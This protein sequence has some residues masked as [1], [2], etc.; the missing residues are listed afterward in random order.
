MDVIK[1]EFQGVTA[2]SMLEFLKVDDTLV[3]E[4]KLMNKIQ[5]MGVS[6]VDIE[7]F[8]SS[9]NEVNMLNL[10]DSLSRVEAK[11]QKVLQDHGQISYEVMNVVALAHQ[12]LKDVLAMHGNWGK[13]QLLINYQ[14]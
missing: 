5:E 9:F 4:I 11:F 6:I 2:I 12:R 8:L 7:E 13:V 1:V 14:N 10:F 3:P